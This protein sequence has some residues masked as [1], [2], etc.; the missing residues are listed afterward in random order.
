MPDRW[1]RVDPS[2]QARRGDRRQGCG[3]GCSDCCSSFCTCL[4]RVSHART[5]RQLSAGQH[6]IVGARRQQSSSRGQLMTQAVQTPAVSLVVQLLHLFPIYGRGSCRVLCASAALP[7]TDALRTTA[8]TCMHAAAS[9]RNAAAPLPCL[10][11]APLRR[12][13]LSRSCSSQRVV[14]SSCT[15][16]PA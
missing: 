16:T 7:G 15:A 14:S 5:A 9:R 12:R 4:L 1:R 6:M 10:C 3:W 13:R 8:A 11:S 2:S